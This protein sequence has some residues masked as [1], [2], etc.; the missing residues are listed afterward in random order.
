[1]AWGRGGLPE[2][3][4]ARPMSEQLNSHSH[5]DKGLQY[6]AK[7]SGEPGS[8]CDASIV[9]PMLPDSWQLVR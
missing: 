3:G 4:I 7:R 5:S 8:R 6:Y 9:T 1:M 2:N